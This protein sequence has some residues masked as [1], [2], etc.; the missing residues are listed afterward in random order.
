MFL[1]KYS[2]GNVEQEIDSEI[3]IANCNQITNNQDD[4]IEH[5]KKALDLA[6]ILT[7]YVK[8]C[9]VS[10]KISICYNK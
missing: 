1:F 8:C 7:S 9:E 2:A 4:A 3:E 6:K 10:V 5:F